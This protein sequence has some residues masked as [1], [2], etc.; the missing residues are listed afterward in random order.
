MLSNGIAVCVGC[1]RWIHANPWDA[2]PFLRSAVVD[3]DEL[4]QLSRTLKKREAIREEPEVPA[5]E[6]LSP[7]KREARDEHIRELY[8]M[9]K[10]RR[11]LAEMFD[12]TPQ[13]IDQ[14]V[15]YR[16]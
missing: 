10:T 16:R 1:H 8:A 13:R 3:F 5:V 7:P 15:S 2:E 14:I 4:Q 12:L 9:G 6:W 11:E